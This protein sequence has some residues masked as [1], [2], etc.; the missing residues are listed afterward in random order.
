MKL[1]KP[2]SMLIATTVCCVG[3]VSCGS[4]KNFSYSDGLDENGFFKGVK[5]SEIVTLPTYKGIEIG[6]D[7]LTA[8]DAAVQEQVDGLL[9]DYVTYEPIIDGV[10]KDGDTV[11][12]A[13]E[14]SIDGVLFDGGSTNG[15]GVDVTIGV[16]QYIDDFLE[17]LIGH[18][19]GDIVNVEVTFP[20]PYQNN[21]DLA[22]KDALF[23][24]HIN[25]ICGDEIKATLTDEIAQ[26]YGFDTADELLADI[27]DWVVEN[28]KQRMFY[29]LL[30]QAECENIPDS[31]L[32]YV[33]KY[34]LAYYDSYAEMYGCTVE[35]L[36]INQLGYESQDAYIADKME[37]FRSSALQ[38]MAAQAIAETEGL[39]V[40]D[41]DIE[42]A[43]YTDRIEQYGKP[44]IKQYVLFQNIL[45]EFIISNG[46]TK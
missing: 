35:E 46:I 3:L 27:A 6:E 9:A 8:S 42:E 36:I 26:G 25:Y 11:N 30:L 19:P 43:G 4:E 15:A 12:I 28:N 7:I 39:T 33:I 16:T 14:G 41:A 23:V 34:D 1:C 37:D 21:P 31:V 2:I 5:A 29:E 24:T 38:Y 32:D 45:P 22:G 44:Y 20:T 13:Y 10:I 40:T 18:K 17:Q